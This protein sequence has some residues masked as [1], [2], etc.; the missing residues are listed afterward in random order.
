MSQ[1]CGG[2]DQ[3]SLELQ[4]PQHEELQPQDQ[5]QPEGHIV[6]AAAPWLGCGNEINRT[7][8]VF[9]RYTCEAKGKMLWDRVD[10]TAKNTS[11]LLCRSTVLSHSSQ[12]HQ[13]Q[14]RCTGSCGPG[15]R[16]MAPVLTPP[17]R[18][19]KKKSICSMFSQSCLN[20]LTVPFLLKAHQNSPEGILLVW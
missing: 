17:P 13:P 5:P 11:G 12:E 3:H 2:T 15:G 16:K 1:H 18:D 10:K 14:W 7:K 8:L 6:Q 4:K 19:K 20:Y 9:W